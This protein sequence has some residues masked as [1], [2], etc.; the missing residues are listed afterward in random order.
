M[1]DTHTSTHTQSAMKGRDVLP[2]QTKELSRVLGCV[3]R[4]F[5]SVSIDTREINES[6]SP[7]E[8]CS[9]LC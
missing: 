7:N 3:S 6:W 5:R 1:S 8:A 4:G 2:G 9:I